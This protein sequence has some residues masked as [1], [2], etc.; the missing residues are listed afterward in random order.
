M[1]LSPWVDYRPTALRSSERYSY[2]IKHQ[3][4]AIYELKFVFILTMCYHYVWW[5]F[6][7]VIAHLFLMDDRSFI[8]D[9]DSLRVKLSFIYFG[10]TTFSILFSLWLIYPTLPNF[11]SIWVFFEIALAHLMHSS[12]TCIAREFYGLA[13][14]VLGSI[15]TWRLCPLPF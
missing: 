5:L 15:L 13:D 8:S 14:V 9:V 7:S 4:Q 2:T 3:Y 6:I 12:A 11:Y 10:V 1:L